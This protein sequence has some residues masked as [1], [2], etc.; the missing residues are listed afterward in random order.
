[1]KPLV[2]MKSNLP[3]ILKARICRLY[4]RAK[5]GDEQAL[6]VLENIGIKGNKLVVLRKI[7][8]MMKEES[9]KVS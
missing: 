2:T 3:A 6:Y 7:E 5:K 1:M 8:E 9:V 4:Q